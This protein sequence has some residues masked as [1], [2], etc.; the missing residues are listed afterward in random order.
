M[1]RL[2]KKKQVSSEKGIE[3]VNKKKPEAMEPEQLEQTNEQQ[4]GVSTEQT[5]PAAENKDHA[6]A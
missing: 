1:F 4:S 5:G 6:S 2:S 3:A